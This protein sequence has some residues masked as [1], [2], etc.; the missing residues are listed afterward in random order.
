MQK[1]VDITYAAVFS[2]RIFVLCSQRQVLE[3]MMLQMF[4]II[5]PN[6]FSSINVTWYTYRKTLF[7]KRGVFGMVPTLWCQLC[8]SLLYWGRR[9]SCKQTN[10]IV[11]VISTNWCPLRGTL[12]YVKI[13]ENFKHQHVFVSMV[14]RFKKNTLRP[15]CTHFTSD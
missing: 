7:P 3:L 10:R 13:S 4:W 6:F 12:L 2:D 11:G 1:R 5:L 9:E 15:L 14:T 8:S